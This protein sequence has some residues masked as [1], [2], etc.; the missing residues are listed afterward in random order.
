MRL[1]GTALTCKRRDDLKHIQPPLQAL[2]GHP[3]VVADA[4]DDQAVPSDAELVLAGHRVANVGDRVALEFDQLVAARAVQVIVLGVAVVVLVNRAAAKRHLAQN[5]SLD[6]L[7]ER[8][9]HS[10]PAHFAVLAA[11]GHL[12]GQLV[13]VEMLVS[14]ADFFDDQP[15]LLRDPLAARLQEFLEPRQRCEGDFDSA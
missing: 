2:L 9:I 10:R 3:A 5:A 13:G 14:L 11:F 7:A 1:S 15:P 4:G 12:G 6:E 8:A